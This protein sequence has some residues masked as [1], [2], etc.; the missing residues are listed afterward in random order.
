M[1]LHRSAYSMALHDWRALCPALRVVRVRNKTVIYSQGERCSTSYIIARGHIKLSRISAQ[2]D[3]H[4]IAMLPADEVCGASLAGDDTGPVADTATAKGPA[5]LYCIPRAQFVHAVSREPRAAAFVIER[6]ARREAFLASRIEQL[7][8]GDVRSRV[9]AV[10]SALI[11]AY[12]G[13]C[14]HGHEVDIRL[15]QQELAEMTG[16]SRPTVSTILNRMRDQGI[17]SYT[18]AYICVEN[19]RALEQLSVADDDAR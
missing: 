5:E 11:G 1:S 15:T 7:L 3:E 14:A 6:L 4:T 9:A 19:R 13:R 18:R 16:A 2:G 17:V 10:L 8:N 12:G